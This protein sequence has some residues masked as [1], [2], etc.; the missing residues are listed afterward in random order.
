[1]KEESVHVMLRI[2][3]LNKKEISENDKPCI[4][5]DSENAITINDFSNINGSRS[6]TFDKIFTEEHSQK[7]IYDNSAFP[8][9]EWLFEGFNCTVF[10]YGQTGCGKTHTMMGDALSSDNMGI[11]PR[12]FAHCRSIVC[13]EKKK[14]FLLKASYL[15]IY[16]ECVFDLLSDK[17]TKLELKEEAKKG[18]Y[19]KD[20]SIHNVRTL[21][22]MRIIMDKGNKA[23][24]VGATS[25]NQDSSR[26]HS[27][28]TLYVEVSEETEGKSRYTSSKLSLVDLAGS[29]RA[30][31]TNAK[32]DRLK[33]GNMINLSLS[34]L[35]NVIQALVDGKSKFVPYRAS[36]LTRLLQDSLGGNTRTLMIAAVSPGFSSFEETLSTLRYANRTKNIKNKPKVNMDEKDL[37]IKQYADEIEEL[38]VVLL[39]NHSR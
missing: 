16:N 11:I 33:E 17:R 39:E 7:T 22:E 20:L 37:A 35:G 25:M 29:E 32:G 9:V 23:R 21:D 3:P 28:F 19:V 8:I 34:A 4:T 14:N 10:A 24:T 6:F 31:K 26:S 30:T 1:M 15:E 12:T 13:E 27:I 38:K 36:K 5:L 18:V 2:R